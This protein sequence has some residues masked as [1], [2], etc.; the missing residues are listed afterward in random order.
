MQG[1]YSADGGCVRVGARLDEVPDDCPLTSW[2]PVR[3]SGFAIGRRVEG[4][5]TATI[6]GADVGP[7]RDEVSGTVNVVRERSSVQGGVV[8]IDLRVAHSDEELVAAC[9]AG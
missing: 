1:R 2:I 4:F 7:K 6:A 8:L 5:G 3:T 9:Q